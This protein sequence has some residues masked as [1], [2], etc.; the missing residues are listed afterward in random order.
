MPSSWALTSLL[1]HGIPKSK[2]RRGWHSHLIFFFNEAPILHKIS[3]KYH[4][5][6][7]K[8]WS[9]RLGTHPGVR[10]PWVRWV[11]FCLHL[12]TPHQSRHVPSLRFNHIFLSGLGMYCPYKLL[13]VLLITSE[14][15]EFT[16]Q[17][18]G[19]AFMLYFCTGASWDPVFS[20]HVFRIIACSVLASE[21]HVKDFSRWAH[22]PLHLLPPFLQ[23]LPDET[24]R[25][26]CSRR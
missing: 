9:P 17:L 6:L 12:Y 7:F 15:P 5:C 20:L 24:Y 16:R 18:Q 4:Y 26:R 13:C 1:G 25:K 2:G 21:R 10:S 23:W 3:T 14:C 8:N 22:I 19:T 11:H